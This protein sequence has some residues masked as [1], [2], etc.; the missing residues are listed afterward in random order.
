VNGEALVA[1]LLADARANIL[2]LNDAGVRVTPE[3]ADERARNWVMGL[4]GGYEVRPR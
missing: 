3:Q 1:A 2:K 4:L